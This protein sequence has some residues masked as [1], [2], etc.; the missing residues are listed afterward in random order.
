MNPPVCPDHGSPMKAYPH[1]ERNK[2]GETRW[3]C[4]RKDGAAYCKRKV[5]TWEQ[6]EA[7]QQ[8]RPAP[9]AKDYET[10]PSPYAEARLRAAIAALSITK[11]DKEAA[12]DLYTTFLMA[13][14]HDA[15]P[16]E[17]WQH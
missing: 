5:S 6:Q 10:Q 12:M 2:P 11:G 4:S 1:S 17:P 13:A 15:F 8:A 9:T 16:E 7:P 14:Y 3:F